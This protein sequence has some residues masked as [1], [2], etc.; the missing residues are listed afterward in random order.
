MRR[1]VHD[2]RFDVLALF[3]MPVDVFD[4]HRRIVDE[5]ADR[6]GEAAERHDVERFA[7]RP[8]RRDGAENRQRNGNR[9]DDRRAPAAEEDED[10]QTR[11]RRG[12]DALA[13]NAADRRVHE[14][15][16]IADEG[17]GDVFRDERPEVFHLPLDA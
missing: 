15:R 5:N 3:E 9:D 2:G 16:L 14:Q 17:N 1:A 8:K 7:Q 13:D 10:H 12:D 6:Q 4:R 11:Q